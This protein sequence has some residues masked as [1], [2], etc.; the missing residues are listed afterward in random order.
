MAESNDKRAI[1]TALDTN[2]DTVGSAMSV[3][4]LPDKYT[5]SLGMQ[6]EP[7]NSKQWLSTTPGNLVLTLYFDAYEEKKD[8]TTISGPIKSTLDPANSG[9][10]IVGCLFT[11][12]KQQYKGLIS[13]I[14]EEFSLF[15]P[16]GTPARSK[17]TLTL[18]A[19]PP[20]SAATS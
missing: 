1:L 2:G 10:E 16:N 20:S 14:S 17:I 11:W 9:G 5:L 12:G 8:V 6:Y 18:Q 19:W 4:Y 3:Q 13:G 7:K 15:H